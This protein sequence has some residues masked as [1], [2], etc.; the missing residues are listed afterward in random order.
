MTS[1]KS[2]TAA[3]LP[4]RLLDEATNLSAGCTSGHNGLFFTISSGFEDDGEGED[5]GEELAELSVDLTAEAC[6]RLLALLCNGQLEADLGNTLIAR[7]EEDGSLEIECLDG[8]LCAQVHEVAVDR[9]A[10]LLSAAL[11]L[12]DLTS[13]ADL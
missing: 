6:E 13:D 12:V 8:E 2:D 9:L 10:E 7:L 1:T 5:P 4:L 3:T 11:Q